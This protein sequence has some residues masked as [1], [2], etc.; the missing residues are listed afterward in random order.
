MEK[1][2]A[3]GLNYAADEIVRVMKILEGKASGMCFG[4]A[5]CVIAGFPH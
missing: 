1:S 5:L 4:P 3:Q 2:L